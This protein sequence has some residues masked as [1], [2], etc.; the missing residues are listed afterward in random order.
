MSVSTYASDNKKYIR[1]GS[2]VKFVAPAG[3]YFDVNNKLVAGTPTRADEKFTIWASPTE[4][5]LDG[6]AQ[7]LGAYQS[8]YGNGQ[9]MLG[10]LLNPSGR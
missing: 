6:T 4:I 2:L 5:I 3:Y 7:G 1:V 8:Q 9:G 10:S